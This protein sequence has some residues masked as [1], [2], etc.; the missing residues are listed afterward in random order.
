MD[1]RITLF[2]EV[3]DNGHHDLGS[4]SILSSAIFASLSGTG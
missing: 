3:V 4:N 2:E 1:F